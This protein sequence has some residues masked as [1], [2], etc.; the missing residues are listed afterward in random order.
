MGTRM[1][2]RGGPGRRLSGPHPEDDMEGINHPTGR[3]LRRLLPFA[4][5]YRAKI[6]VALLLTVVVALTGL[7]TPALAQIG[8]DKGITVGNEKVLLLTVA[9]FVLIGVIGWGA[10]Y[11]QTFLSSWIG[12]RMLYDLRI[13]LF[14]HFMALELG[15]HERSPTGRSVSRLTSDIEQLND[16]VTDGFTSVVVN[17]LT[18]IGVIVILFIYDWRLALL[19]LAVFPFLV[20]GTAWFRVTSARAYRRTRETVADVLTVLQENLAG[21]RVVQGFGRQEPARLAFQRANEDYRQANM[22]TI[23]LSALYFPGIELLSGIGLAIVLWFGSLGVLDHQIQVGVMVAFIG[24]LASFFDPIQSLSQLYDDFQSS[25]AALEKI[26]S[27]FDTTPKLADPPG[28][29]DIPLID[30][31]IDLDHV[32]FGYAPDAPVIHDISLHIDAGETVALVGATGAGKSTVAKLIARLYD[33][34]S[35]E[36]SIDGYRLRDIRLGS[37]REQLAIVPQEG[38]LFACTLRENLI[39]ARPDATD[40]QVLSALVAVGGDDMLD[41]LPDGLETIVNE[42]GSGLSAGQR[43]LIAFARALV[44]DPR[45]LIL[46]EATSS[47]DIRSEQ[48]IEHA[49]D[50]LLSGRTSILIA[51]RLSTIRNADRIVVLDHGRIVEQGSHDQLLDLGGRYARLYGD[52]ELAVSDPAT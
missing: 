12:E 24:Y 37:L 14:S 22:Q 30:G 27:V 40:D 16:L 6:I 38:H 50:V 28:A 13:K 35:G 43:Q 11:A 25:M 52:W 26:H 2:G 48:R 36:V 8:I 33:P 18:F 46:D 23:R 39:F 10:G 17:T 4:R 21:V 20:A 41:A 19:S 7:A 1:G 51:H 3:Q 32:T 9:A 31:S 5:P 45:L 29:P 49:M 47:V 42:R 44:A 34:Q 15:Y